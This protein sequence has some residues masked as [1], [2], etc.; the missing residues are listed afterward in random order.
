MHLRR[1]FFFIFETWTNPNARLRYF[2]SRA[3]EDFKIDMYFGF[4][5]KKV[6]KRVII[7]KD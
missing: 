1:E 7:A 4:A 3:P 5:T 6:Q 2:H